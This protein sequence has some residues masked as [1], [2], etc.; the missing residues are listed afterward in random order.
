MLNTIG[1]EG[2]KK[3]ALLLV[4][5]RFKIQ[6]ATQIIETIAGRWSE[7]MIILISP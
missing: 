2:N 3:P 5:S 6:H 4:Y 1:V 7:V